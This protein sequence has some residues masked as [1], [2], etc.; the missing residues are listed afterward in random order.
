MGTRH[1]S[2]GIGTPALSVAGSPTA[3]LADAKAATL[4]PLNTFF[5]SANGV[6]PATGGHLTT[7]AGIQDGI[8]SPTTG[9]RFVAW[10]ATDSF[11]RRIFNYQGCNAVTAPAAIN[12]TAAAAIAGA[13]AMSNDCTPR[14]H[15]FGTMSSDRIN[16][17]QNARFDTDSLRVIPVWVNFNGYHGSSYHD[18]HM[19]V[20]GSDGKLQHLSNGAAN[21]GL[22]RTATTGGGVKRRELTWADRR[23]KTHRVILSGYGYFMGVYI[24]TNATIRRTPNKPLFMGGIDS[25]WE[26]NGC[27]W[28]GSTAGGAW[29]ASTGSY[30]CLGMPEAISFH[31]G[32]PVGTTG[33]G[34]SGWQK[35]NGVTAGEDPNYNTAGTAACQASNIRMADL[36]A[37]FSEQYPIHILPGSWNDGTALGTPYQTTYRTRMALGF[38]K[39]IAYAAALNRDIKFITGQIQPVDR[40]NGDVYDQSDAGIAEIPALYPSNCL[41]ILN[42]RS[43]WL[44]TAYPSGSR[45]IYCHAEPFSAYIHL[46]LLGF[47]TVGRYIA[48]QLGHISVPLDYVQ[49]AQAW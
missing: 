35:A 12:T 48:D 42:L 33:E 40:A 14:N 49:K 23:M 18:M 8:P 24:D 43:M 22:P 25:W 7:D 30:Q 4:V 46:W 28:S 31:I 45:S 32:L 26:G 34:G 9:L 44:D 39:M 6:Y 20:E 11:G 10:D 19:Q 15:G 2:A 21:N 1:H 41:G 16:G 13:T 27:A 17:T 37:K 36:V 3:T 38:T 47:M 5:E 29:G